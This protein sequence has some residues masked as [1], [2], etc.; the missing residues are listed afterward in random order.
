MRQVA[1]A[2]EQIR[3]L[4]ERKINS[5]NK[6]ALDWQKRTEDANEKIYQLERAE[7]GNNSRK[8]QGLE[9]MAISPENW[10]SIRPENLPIS[11]RFETS[12]KS[13]DLLTFE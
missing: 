4:S 5:S 13:L 8:S 11:D 3:I 10:L 12:F 9:R 7:V 1:S 2:A 6:K